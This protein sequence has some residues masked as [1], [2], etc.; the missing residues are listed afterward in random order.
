MSDG[1]KKT[2]SQKYKSL[3]HKTTRERAECGDAKRALKVY[4][5]RLQDL[6]QLQQQEGLNRWRERLQRSDKSCYKW[7]ADQKIPPMFLCVMITFNES[8]QDIAGFWQQIWNRPT[9]SAH[10]YELSA[11]NIPEVSHLP[12]IPLDPCCVQGVLARSK[13][14]AGGLDG[15]SGN[16]VS[17]LPLPVV[18]ELTTLFH[19]FE[20]MA[21]FD[22]G[23][24][25]NN[26][27]SPKSLT[28]P[29]VVISDPFQ[30]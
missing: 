12:S 16:E 15:W 25:L 5:K 2:N 22:N 28:R 10:A 19:L 17:E 24:G 23:I 30:C 27:I 14:K 9:D 4:Q 7:L 20:K 1:E 11:P 26:P 21:R 13:G 18:A 29:N 8:L 6:R 3:S